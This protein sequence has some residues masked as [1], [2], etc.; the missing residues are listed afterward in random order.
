[1]RMMKM[2]LRYLRNLDQKVNRLK[3]LPFWIILEM[4]KIDFG[5][6]AF[7]SNFRI[8]VSQGILYKQVEILNS[9]YIKIGAIFF[10]KW[11]S[12]N[13]LHLHSMQK[14]STG[15]RS[16]GKICEVFNQFN[17]K[18]GYKCFLSRDGFH[19]ISKGVSFVFTKI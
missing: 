11:F 8:Q 19:S 5:L 17:A 7:K 10:K 9:L 18:H 16:D 2:R 14:H 13:N 15:E 3:N 4:A 12:S 1:M 6:S